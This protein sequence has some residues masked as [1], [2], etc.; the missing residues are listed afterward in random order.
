MS[1]DRHRLR[2]T[3]E[4]SAAHYQAARPNYPDQLFAD[5]L[6]LTGLAP[7]ARLLEVGCGPG[8]ATLPL[9]RMGFPI[10]A[11]ELGEQLAAEARR[12]LI[13]FPDVEVHTAP[14]E[15]WEPP[16]TDF[17]LLYA[18]TAWPWVDPEVKYAKAAACLRPGGYLATWHALHALPDGFDPFFSEIQEVYDEIGEGHPGEWPPPPPEKHNSGFADEFEASGSFEPIDERL[19]V[20]ALRYTAEEY[21]ALLDTFSGHIAMEPEKRAYLYGQIRRRLALRPDN[22]VTRHWSSVLTVGR[23]RI[24]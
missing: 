7:P 21:M 14:F 6:D 17:E 8:K 22:S 4:S 19:Y 12:N 3:F 24:R 18:A 16:T 1:S 10:T 11:V 2:T 20:W 5:L 9:A 23:H 13:G 15:T